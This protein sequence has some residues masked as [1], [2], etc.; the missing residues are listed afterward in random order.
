MKIKYLKLKN[1][2]LLSLAGLLGINVSCD[3]MV[4]EYGCPVA[5]YKIKGKVSDPNGNPITGIEVET[6]WVKDTTKSDGSYALLINDFPVETNTF[7]VAFTDI[8]GAE[9]GLYKNDTVPVTFQH[10]ELS[11]G[12][13]NWYEGSATKTLNVTLQ[14]VEK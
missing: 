8:D 7:D 4:S 11:D 12:D 10:S 9:N 2:L 5:D 14:P 1:W 6:R 3:E 13:G